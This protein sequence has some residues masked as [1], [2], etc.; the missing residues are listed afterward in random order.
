M[1]FEPFDPLVETEGQTPARSADVGVV[2]CDTSGTG[3]VEGFVGKKVAAAESVGQ[4]QP[5][6]EVVRRRIDD[7]SQMK[8]R[9]MKR[10]DIALGPEAEQGFGKNPVGTGIGGVVSES[11]T[12]V[13]RREAALFGGKRR[14]GHIGCK[15]GR[16]AAHGNHNSNCRYEPA[17]RTRQQT[18][19]NHRSLAGRRRSAARARGSSVRPAIKRAYGHPRPKLS[20]CSLPERL[21][22]AGE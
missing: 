3:R 11:S 1:R 8:D 17:L 20:A 22:L 12:S 9:L 2:Q 16:P 14:L 4:V 21:R 13:L 10:T 15:G 5:R 7:P 6:E 18:R 19:T